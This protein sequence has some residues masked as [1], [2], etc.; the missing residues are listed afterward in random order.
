M[1]NRI[2]G[3]FFALGWVA[4]GL[5]SSSLF[6]GDFFEKDGV[7]IHGFDPVAYFTDSKPVAGSAEFTHVYKGS[8]F[9]FAN[10]KNQ[11]E[12][13]KAPEKFAPQYNGY[14]AYGVSKGAKAKIEP[15]QF[16]IVEGKLFLNYD[17]SIA[18][19][20][21]ADKEGFIKKANEK[22]PEVTK[23]TKVVY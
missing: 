19:K 16:A 8:T 17:S 9:R 4:F 6:A 5:A 22:W 13:A 20:W 11:K 23:L 14:C 7:A 2:M 21:N 1:N 18:K 12:F 15:E 3:A 10:A